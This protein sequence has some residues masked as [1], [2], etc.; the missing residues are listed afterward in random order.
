MSVDTAED[1]ARRHLRTLAH[2]SLRFF[3]L[4]VQDEVAMAS[5]IA[6]REERGRVFEALCAAIGDGDTERQEQAL[7][8]LTG[9]AR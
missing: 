3:Y 2:R 8:Q 4:S 6:D 9:A 5:V 1:T 7:D